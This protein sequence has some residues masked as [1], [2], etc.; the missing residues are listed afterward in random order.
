MELLIADVDFTHLRL[1]M[2]AGLG[3]ECFQSVVLGGAVW[4]V[5]VKNPH[6]FLGCSQMVVDLWLNMNVMSCC[7]S[8]WSA[9]RAASWELGSASTMQYLSAQTI[10]AGREHY[11]SAPERYKFAFDHR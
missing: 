2:L 10:L 1:H 8:G 4:A 9:A 11:L 5:R 7:Q 6:P 3:L